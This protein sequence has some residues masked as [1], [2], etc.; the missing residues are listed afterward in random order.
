MSE[1]VTGYKINDL[2][3]HVKRVVKVDLNK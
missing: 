3:G 2:Y 1:R